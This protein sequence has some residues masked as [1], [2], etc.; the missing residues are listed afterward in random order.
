[1]SCWRLYTWKVKNALYWRTDNIVI[2]KMN[3]DQLSLAFPIFWNQNICVYGRVSCKC[4]F[5]ET[6]SLCPAFLLSTFTTRSYRVS[7]QAACGKRWPGTTLPPPLFSDNDSVSS[8]DNISRPS[9]SSAAFTS[10]PPD[11]PNIRVYSEC[12]GVYRCTV[13]QTTQ[14]LTC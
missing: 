11:L 14:H 12:T 5:L 4:P 13:T 1:M 6:W 8:V 10:P 9:V 7:V 2:I 3:N